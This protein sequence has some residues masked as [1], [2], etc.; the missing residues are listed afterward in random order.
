MIGFDGGGSKNSSLRAKRFLVEGLHDL[1][2]KRNI[3]FFFLN[4]KTQGYTGELGS[5]ITTTTIPRQRRQKCLLVFFNAYKNNPQAQ[6][7]TVVAF[8]PG[9]FRV[10]YFHEERRFKSLLS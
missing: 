5:E 4:G 8:Y 2:S 7:I 9:V 1:K 10:P 6:E 3:F